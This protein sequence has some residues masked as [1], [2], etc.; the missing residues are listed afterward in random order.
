MVFLGIDIGGTKRVVVVGDHTGKPLVH[1]R[2]PMEHSGDWRADLDC[3]IDDA[4]SLLGDWETKTGEGLGGVGASVPGPADAARGILLNPPNLPHWHNAPV[5]AALREAFGVE[6][7]IE[8]DANAA[9]LAEH[10]YGAGRG[11]RDMIYLTM[12]TGVGAGLIAG[13]QLLTG[14]YGGAGEAGHVPVEF[15]GIPC[16]CGLHGC[17]EAYVG[18]HAWQARLREVVPEGSDVLSRAGGDRNAIRPEH[19]V[20]AAREGDRFACQEFDRWLDYL[21]RGIVP[22]VMA[23]EPERIVLG[24][25]ATAAGQTL[26]FDPLRERVAAALWPHQAER[27]SIV[28]AELGDELPQLAGLAVALSGTRMDTSAS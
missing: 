6:V 28:P 20:L 3:L 19:L 23:L 11:V 14:A 7:R 15:P 10:A 24:T 5:G 16:R 12:S 22:L 18:G 1:I 4:R 2:R 8:N 13:G 27:L 21:A 17:L 9:A 25:I 26:C